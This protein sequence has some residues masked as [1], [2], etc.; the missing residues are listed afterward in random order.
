[1]MVDYLFTS[2]YEW[3]RHQ[4][5]GKRRLLEA[6]LDTIGID[7][8]PSGGGFFLMGRLPTY[9]KRDLEMKLKTHDL[10]VSDDPHDWMVCKALSIDF[11]VTAIPASPFFSEPD[12]Y[13]KLF[14]RGLL[15]R[16]AFCKKSETLEEVNRRLRK[17]A[18]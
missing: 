18:P 1:M 11:G 17:S 7:S 12:Q 2:Y 16:F 10:F 9:S 3:L 15:A 5:L 13:D 14:G 4:F 6:G 8:I